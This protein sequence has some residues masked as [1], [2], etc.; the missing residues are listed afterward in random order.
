MLHSYKAI[1]KTELSVK[2]GAIVYVFE[3]NLNG[4]WFVDSSDGQGYLPSCILKR[5][6]G[7][8]NLAPIK[9][10]KRK[11]KK[12]KKEEIFFSF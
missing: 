9:L 1:T 2:K 6:N 3:K 10:D 5:V 12:F 7:Q 11:L 8:E 4:W